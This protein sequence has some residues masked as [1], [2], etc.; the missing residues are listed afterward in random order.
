[1]EALSTC[2]Q[3]NTDPMLAEAMVIGEALSW[4]KNKG[5][6]GVVVETDC[7]AAIQAIRSTSTT[8]SYLGRVI[9]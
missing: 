7:L 4:V 1:M 9:D 8:L 6:I 5:W 3:G 2:K